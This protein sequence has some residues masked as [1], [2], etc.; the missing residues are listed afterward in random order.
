MF[1]HKF[2]YCDKC[3]IETDKDKYIKMEFLM[4]TLHIHKKYTFIHLYLM[5]MS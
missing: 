4:Q 1:L 3:K 2:A 5:Q